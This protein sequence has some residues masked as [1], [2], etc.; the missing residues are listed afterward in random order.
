MVV[1]AVLSTRVPDEPTR[2]IS[3]MVTTAALKFAGASLRSTVKPLV[4]LVLLADCEPPQAARTR[5]SDA[6]NELR[7]AVMVSSRVP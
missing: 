1:L 2:S 4:P 6:A 3:E 5:A 7:D